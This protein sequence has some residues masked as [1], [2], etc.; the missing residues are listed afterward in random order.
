MFDTSSQAIPCPVCAE[1]GRDTKIP[2]DTQ[3]LLL[4]V[5]FACPVCG[6]EIGLAAESRDTVQN[7]MDGLEEL[8]SQMDSQQQPE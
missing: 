8:K 3:Q 4:G 1:Q 5:Q 2:F 7:A 6:S